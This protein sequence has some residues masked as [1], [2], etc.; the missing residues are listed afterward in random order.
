MEI[1]AVSV[2]E[3]P[4]KVVFETY[5]DKLVDLVPFLPNVDRI[6]VKSRQEVSPDVIKLDN[7]WSAKADIPMVVQ[8]IVKPEMLQWID[9]AVWNQSEWSCQWSFELMF[10]KE[11]VQV[12]GKN[13][14]YELEPNK[15]QMDIN[16]DLSIDVAK[17]PGIP[18]FLASTVKPQVEK[19]IRM[20]ITPNLT[21]VNQGLEDY[22]KKQYK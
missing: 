14:F 18:K 2:L 3:Y 16:G 12:S 13:Y 8:S 10:M 9:H 7:L 22:L 6:E 15:T 20:L 21:K 5:R 1:K 19:F 4:R 11:Y 17:I